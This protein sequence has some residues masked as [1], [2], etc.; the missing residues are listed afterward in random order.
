MTPSRTERTSISLSFETHEKLEKLRRKR[1][2]FDHLIR[3]L[4]GE[5]KE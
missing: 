4:M 2:T 5:K 1:E 3:R